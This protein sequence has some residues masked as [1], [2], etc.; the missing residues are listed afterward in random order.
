MKHTRFL[1]APALIA[2]AL[3]SHVA[4]AS[5]TYV[6]NPGTAAGNPYTAG[7]ADE[8]FSITTFAP[9]ETVN[10][11]SDINGLVGTN[12]H[13]YTT[14]LPITG[15]SLNKKIWFENT[16]VIPGGTEFMLCFDFSVMLESGS[17][18]GGTRIANEVRWFEGA[19]ALSL[20]LEMTGGNNTFQNYA[21]S[22][23]GPSSGN[24]H[25]NNTGIL[26]SRGG[27]NNTTF[28]NFTDAN[29]A[30]YTA[31]AIPVGEFGVVELTD[32]TDSSKDV[33]FQQ[34][35]YFFTPVTDLP[36]NTR[37]QFS[38]GGV[39]AIVDPV[40]EPGRAALLLAGLGICAGRRNRR[41]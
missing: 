10:F 26:R 35:H 34:S 18:G 17:P 23:S 29:T 33:S 32:P 22:P 6:A 5:F 12:S 30:N 38:F 9:G 37:F 25:F 40:P 39:E 31:P 14:G 27:S 24:T 20:D 2:S 15:N 7:G 3:S 19:P 28:I 8:I 36:A 16:D 4:F 1:L 11:S 13:D 21:G 41:R